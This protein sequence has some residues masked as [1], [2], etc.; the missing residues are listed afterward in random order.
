MRAV[1]APDKFK[2]SLT[3]QEAAS[4]IER[5][6]RASGRA[7]EEIVAIPMADGGEGTVE[8]FLAGGARRTR[9][10]VRG[11][12]G[13]PVSATFAVDGAAAIVEMSAASGLLLIP[14]EKRDALRA[15]SFGTG[16]LIRAALDERAERIL[17]GIG[18]SATNDA[19]AG[20]LAAL[21]ARLLDGAGH[22]L[23]AGGAA[24]ARLAKIDLGGLDPRLKGVAIDVAADVDNPLCG[25]NGASAIFGPQK[26]ASPED[27]RVLDR[28]LAHFADVSA[29]ELGADHRNDPGAGAAG[30]LGFALRAF[31]GAR[32]RPG[33]E[34]VAELRGLPKALAG[35][36]AVFTG[37]GSIDEQTLAGKTVAGVARLARAAG[38][39]KIVAFG[40]RVD[41]AAA[42]ALRERYG[43]TT[44]GLAEEGYTVER[45]MREA[46]TLLERAVCTFM[47]MNGTS[48]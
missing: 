14:G 35:A 5:G 15:T 9:V 23:E 17:V 45:A 7:F 22:A 43:V 36:S 12:L 10:T 33:V 42:Q 47:R 3:A 37:E 34:I 48:T 40:G 38:V 20:M 30:G 21:G 13:E 24:L 18:G 8:A 25:P 39:A 27:V 4:A 16:E 19:G 6:L 44:V 32:L 1:I 11:P 2:G 41:P 46:A 26:G 28:A 29:A 31:L